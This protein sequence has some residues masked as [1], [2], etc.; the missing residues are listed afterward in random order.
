MIIKFTS[1]SLIDV[2]GAD[3]TR[4]LLSGSIELDDCQTITINYFLNHFVSTDG[5]E[6]SFHSNQGSIILKVTV[7]EMHNLIEE[8]DNDN[9]SIEL[10][11]EQ[12][13]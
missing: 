6:V 5:A 11:Y 9:P 8:L 4:R 3:Y 13:V 1:N 10:Q 12:G 7:E 2:N